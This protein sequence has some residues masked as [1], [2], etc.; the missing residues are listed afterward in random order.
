MADARLLPGVKVLLA[1]IE[2][3]GFVRAAE[4]RGLSPD[5]TLQAR[6]PCDLQHP[7]K[8]CAVTPC[9]PRP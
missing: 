3:G 1:V 2:T 8:C 6:T 9:S 4:S 5:T 7:G